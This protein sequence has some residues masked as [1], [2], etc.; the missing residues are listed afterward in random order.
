M[1]MRPAGQLHERLTADRW[2]PRGARGAARA[3]KQVPYRMFNHNQLRGSKQRE[4]RPSA[5]ALSDALKNTGGSPNRSP[6]DP[7]RPSPTGPGGA[8]QPRNNGIGWFSRVLF[9]LL[10]VILAYQAW[11]WLGPGTGTQT[12][13]INYSDF[14]TQLDGEHVKSVTYDPSSRAIT[15]TLDHT[16]TV[17]NNGQTV[18]SDQFQT[19]YPFLDDSPLEAALAQHNVQ[20]QGKPNSSGDFWLGLALNVIPIA[21]I[22]VLLFWLSR[23]ATQSQQNIFNFGRSRAKLIMEDAGQVPA[24]RR[25]DSEGLPAGRPSGYRQDATRPGGSR[26]GG[27]AVLF[28]VRLRVRRGARRCRRQPCARPLRSG[29]EGGAQHHLY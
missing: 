23:R 21:L 8:N 26:R 13:T 19:T 17:N 16:I 6:A 25:Q 9:L 4:S 24:A 29:E 27:G 15:G 14:V 7:N 18:T 10:V 1:H 12:A 2:Y 5:P 20:L 22:L 3:R 28:D 11:I